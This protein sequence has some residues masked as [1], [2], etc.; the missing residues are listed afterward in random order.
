MSLF[1]SAMPAPQPSADDVEFWNHCRARRLCF[2]A[3]A[4]CGRVR[5]PPTPVCA[6]CGSLAISWREAPPTGQIYSYSV[7]YHPTL[8]ILRGQ[9]PYI[10]ALVIFPTLDDVRL[11]TNIV[12]AQPDQIAVGMNVELLWDA[13]A[14]GMLLPRFRL[15]R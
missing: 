15:C 6:E 1:P 9:P 11:V 8:D 2:Q 5:H 14:D 13:I 12:D 3:C 7:A 10:I 4:T